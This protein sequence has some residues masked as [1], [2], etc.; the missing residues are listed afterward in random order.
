MYKKNIIAMLLSVLMI[1]IFLTT[2]NADEVSN[3]KDDSLMPHYEQALVLKNLG[4]FNGTDKGFELD[5]SATRA[6]AAALLVRFLGVEN[7]ALDNNYEHP[8]KDVPSWAEPYVGYMYHY[9]L[10][11][12]ISS[13]Q[14]GSQNAINCMQYITFVL[15][16]LGYDDK[17]GDFKWNYSINA[18]YDW[19]IIGEIDY[20]NYLTNYRFLRDDVVNISYKALNRAIKGQPKMRLINKLV[21]QGVISKQTAMDNDFDV[22][23]ELCSVFDYGVINGIEPIETTAFSIDIEDSPWRNKYNKSVRNIRIKI[24]KS[25]LPD[26]MKN[27]TTVDLCRDWQGEM[28]EQLLTEFIVDGEKQFYSFNEYEID[29]EGWI[30]LYVGAKAYD[31]LMLGDNQDNILGYLVMKY[32]FDEDISENPNYDNRYELLTY[33][34]INGMQPLEQVTVTRN[35]L[36]RL[37]IK[38]D[39]SE[40]P[41]AVYAYSESE[42]IDLTTQSMIENIEYFSLDNASY[43]KEIGDYKI[44]EYWGYYIYT[45]YDKDKIPIGYTVIMRNLP[46]NH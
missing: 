37:I 8:F 23:K 34:E 20:E 22:N 6:E 25:K 18:A 42:D 33:G 31:V 29:D 41:N 16:A 44:E 19:G 1:T 2:V 5:R 38:F 46:F 4:L 13:D 27:F 40:L 11:T 3:M 30:L 28:N 7:E 10:T 35:H 39:Q 45:V 32:H 15:R 17:A 9:G 43:C 26:S 14:Y 21:D 12:G 36:G 24:D